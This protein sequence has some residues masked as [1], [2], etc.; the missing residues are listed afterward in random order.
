VLVEPGDVAALRMAVAR[1]IAEPDFR[2]R[3]AEN[4]RSQVAAGL[5]MD[6]AVERF[7]GLLNGLA[8]QGP[9]P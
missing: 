8:E 6:Q 7:L 3:C 5:T 9:T 4:G 1:L 2:H